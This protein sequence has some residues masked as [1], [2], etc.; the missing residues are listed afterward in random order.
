MFAVN[1]G[2]YG[3]E[4]AWTTMLVPWLAGL[5]PQTWLIVYLRVGDKRLMRLHVA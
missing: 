2:K 5:Q 3:F 4:F 1:R